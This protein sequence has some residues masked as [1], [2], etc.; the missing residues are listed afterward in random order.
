VQAQ[1]PNHLKLR[2]SKANVV[3]VQEKARRRSCQ[4]RV[5]ETNASEPPMTCRKRRNGVK[6]GGESLTRDESGGNLLIAQAA[7]GMK[8]A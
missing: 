5:K 8:V 7:P 2:W 4:V 1:A 6:T 3:S